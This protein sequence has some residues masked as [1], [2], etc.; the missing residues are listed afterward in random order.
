MENKK[1]RIVQVKDWYMTFIYMNIPIIGWLYLLTLI[2]RKRRTKD[3]HSQIE[4]KIIR[5]EFAKAFLLYKLTIFITCII[6]IIFLMNMIVPYIEILLA[7]ME[8]L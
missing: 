7:Y 4:S 6:I 3:H 2:L 1:N 8:M 5:A